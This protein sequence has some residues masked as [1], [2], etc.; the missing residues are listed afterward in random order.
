VFLFTH[1]EKCAGTSFNEML[2]ITFLRYF[3][4]TKNHFGGNDV[5]NDLTITQFQ[6]ILK[7]YP[8]GIGGHS[9]RPYLNLENQLKY[10]PLKITFLRNPLERYMSQYNHELERGFVHTF[11]GFL[12]K[13]YCSDF[14]TKK[15]AGTSD[16]ELASKYLNK[17]D[18]IGDA[19]QYNKS[20]NCLQDLM[21][22]IFYEGNKNLNQRFHNENYLRFEDL[23]NELKDR[24]YDNNKNDIKLYET[25]ILKS[26]LLKKYSDTL[27][28]KQPSRYRMKIV[29]KIDKY[30]R[31]FI[32]DPLRELKK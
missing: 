26:N 20:I 1:I 29:K 3:H 13:Q 4:V 14:I 10:K 16:F 6:K 21:N 12:N 11:E 23:N 8:S 32:V 31:H 25:F 30:K 9:I 27:N 28:C 7:Y 18:F 24:V 2:S 17:F 5:R 19:N 22:I 15:I